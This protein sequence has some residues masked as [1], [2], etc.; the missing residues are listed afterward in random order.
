MSNQ[1]VCCFG[2]DK[3]G[4]LWIGTARG[5][6]K[7]NGY[8]YLQYIHSDKDSASLSHN[9]VQKV[10]IDSKGS[11]WALTRFG[12]NRLNEQERFTHI[13]IESYSQNVLHITESGHHRIFINTVISICEYI[14][15]QDRFVEKIRLPESAPPTV[16]FLTD[17]MNRLWCIGSESVE[18]YDTNRFERIV[19]FRISG[20]IHTVYNHTNGEIWLCTENRLVVLD[21]KSLQIVQPPAEIRNHPV[22]SHAYISL[23]HAYDAGNLLLQTRKH[24]WFLYNTYSGEVVHQS[25]TGFPFKV[26]DTAVTAMFTDSHHNLWMGSFDQGFFV[27]YY[28]KQRFN[29]NENLQIHTRNKSVLSMCM[30]KE[31]NLW[32]ATRRHGMMVWDMKNQQIRDI[33]TDFLTKGKPYDHDQVLGMF[34]DSKNN[35]WLQTGRKLVKCRYRNKQLSP[36]QTFLIPAVISVMTEDEEGTIWAAGTD[37]DIHCLQEGESR[38]T[39]IEL[40]PRTYAFTN[41]LVSFSGGKMLIAS[42][43]RELQLLDTHTRHMEEI[44]ILPLMNGNVFVPNVLYEDME[45]NVWIGTNGNGLYRYSRDTQDVMKI[46]GVPCDEISSISGDPQGNIWLGMLYGLAR[47]DPKEKT[48]I[49][50]Y[51][52]DGTGGNQFNERSVCRLPDNSFVFGGT[53]GITYFK[54]EEISAQR[55]I[56]LYIEELGV[57]NRVI[58]IDKGNNTS[59]R[60][61]IRL[62]HNENNIE[63]S[64]SALDYSEY[65]RIKYTFRL[66][67]FYDRWAE[68]RDLRQAFYSNLPAGDYVFEV[69]ITS[70]DH[71]VAETTASLP[72]HI[73]HTPWLSVPAICLYISLFLAVILFIFYLYSRILANRK[74]VQQAIWEKEQEEMTNKMNMSF[75]ANISHEFRTP[76][77]MIS[78][79]VMQLCGDD[80]ITGDN[81]K[82]LYIIQRSINRMLKL[83]NQLMDF[84]KLEND[85]IQL[86]VKQTDIIPELSRLTDIFCLNARI[87][88]ICMIT[89]GLEDSFPMWLDTDKFDKIMGNLL[90]NALKFTGEGGKIIL[91]FDV[92]RRE[93]ARSLFSLRE[94][95]TCPQYAK[96]TVSDTGKG[97]PENKLEKIFE[98]YYQIIDPNKETYNWGT[99]IGL[100][101]ARRLAELH[102]GYLKAANGEKEGSVFTLL[103]PTDDS[104]APEEKETENEAQKDIFPLQTEEQYRGSLSDVQPEKEQ[105][106]LMLVDDDTEIMHYLKTLLS[107]HYR[108]INSFDANNALKLIEEESP[109]LIISDVI[110]P[111]ISGYDFC[112]MIKENLQLCHIPVILVTA[113]TTVEN[114]VE[115]LNV[116]ADAYVTKPFDPAYLLALLKS[117]LK[118]RENIRKLLGRET[119][120]DTIEG[121]ILSAQDKTFMDSLYRLMENELSDPELNITRL[122]EA[123]HISRTKFYY[124]VKG[125]TG[126]NPNVF[127]KTYKLNRAAQLLKEGKYNISEVAD[128]TG[129][130]TLSHFSS[131]FKKQ[132]RVSPSEY[133]P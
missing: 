3:D 87:K 19:S 67:G 52:N 124:K 29:T 49:S 108:I 61:A 34:C 102:H 25:E 41:G 73:S 70:N 15:G 74:S 131:S 11:L 91:S 78:G 27:H 47:Y 2:E 89:T 17:R 6:N 81:K 12:I 118:N 28:H 130:S 116:G 71:S 82:L 132:F 60:P 32:I 95:D 83:V 63:I 84:N 20:V 23:I 1:Q 68:V 75:F 101:Y 33:N 53:H 113:K 122:T 57:D 14:P 123:L 125:L 55:T 66:K 31:L 93:E 80:T 79:P 110:M 98:R 8:Q 44:P 85:T 112:R 90:S 10:F 58:R 43:N 50:Y 126:A 13:P 24:G 36:V 77:T 59:T 119:K 103:L 46:E 109:D 35:I 16:G 88:Q 94:K 37:T 128:L 120:T 21:T 97:I 86:K 127:F 64:Y 38:F 40:Y 72:I 62:R 76:L 117:Q 92:I 42:F 69:K 5:L 107:P 51:S 7:Y 39:S 106:K 45:G 96:L 121:N 99:G 26:P 133:S 115:G 22:L 100:Y 129:F 56:P 54:P 65:H 105:Y 104:Y 111:G 48:F 30:D 9:Y 114:Q 18:C 4:Y